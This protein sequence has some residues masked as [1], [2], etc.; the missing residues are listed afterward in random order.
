MD[1]DPIPHDFWSSVSRVVDIF[2]VWAYDADWDPSSEDDSAQAEGDGERRYEGK[3]R[4]AIYSLDAWFYAARVEGVSLR[5]MW[6]K[7]QQRPDKVWMCFTKAL[8]N[9]D[10]EPFV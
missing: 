9:W 4:V 7:A 10:H 3:V 1:D 2:W 6:K 5:D 8:E